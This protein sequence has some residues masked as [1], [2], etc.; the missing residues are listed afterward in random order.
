MDKVSKIVFGLC[1]ILI[2]SSFFLFSLL[3]VKQIEFFTILSEKPEFIVPAP[4]PVM[5]SRIAKGI[6]M[7]PTTPG[8]RQEMFYTKTEPKVGDIVSFKC[9]TEGCQGNK[10]KRIIDIKDSCYF[11]MGDNREH[12][13]DSRDYGYLCGDDILIRGVLVGQGAC[14]SDTSQDE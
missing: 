3:L 12:S 5:F 7:Q 4:A 13:H 1:G 10:L 8:C 9:S 14:L 6:S 2:V 11:M